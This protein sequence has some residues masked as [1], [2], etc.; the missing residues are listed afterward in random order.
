MS[1]VEK[2]VKYFD[3][4]KDKGCNIKNCNNNTFKT[5]VLKEIELK[6]QNIR[7]IAKINL[8]EEHYKEFGN[9]LKDLNKESG[10]NFKVIRAVEV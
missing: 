10:K 8:C 2:L 3:F 6:K 5:I 9:I 1:L 7:D 4:Q